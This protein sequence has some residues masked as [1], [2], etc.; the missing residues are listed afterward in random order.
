MAHAPHISK[1][2][3][4]PP[5]EADMPAI[6]EWLVRGANAFA[7]H[8][9]FYT[10]NM[11]DLMRHAS[12]ERFEHVEVLRDVDYGASSAE[13]AQRASQR[14]DIW[15]PVRSAAN[16]EPLPVML[17]VHGGGFRTMSKRTHWFFA[18]AFAR[19][20]FVVMTIDYRMGPNH[21]FPEPLIDV[22]Q[23]FEWLVEHAH[24]YGGDLDR[25]VFAGESA[26]ANLLLALTGLC[27]QGAEEMKRFP[28][29]AK[30]V[31]ALGVSPR[32][33]VPMCGIFQVSDP[34]RHR[35]RGVP[36]IVMGPLRDAFRSYLGEE[37]DATRGALEDP[38]SLL[39]DPLCLFEARHAAQ[40]ARRGAKMTSLRATTSTKLPH[41]ML[42]VGGLDPLIDDSRRLSRVWPSERVE[43]CEYARSGHSF[44]AFMWTANA[45]RCWSDI[46]SFLERRQLLPKLSEEGL[47][48]AG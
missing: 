39:A 42:N 19:M 4:T 9:L 25:L 47:L 11:F 30:R 1:N 36:S 3:F 14:L 44:M 31:Q 48:A 2:P 12:S 16:A 22:C 27:T 43:L 5:Q 8:S 35:R 23:A 37:E 24:E 41:L 10:M 40:S 13:F 15:R 46:A 17:F 7:V 32:A 6:P 20:G 34:D 28:A 21:L 18:R 26:G 29:W 33:I 38:L 45:Q